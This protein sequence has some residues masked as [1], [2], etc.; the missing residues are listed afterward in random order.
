MKKKYCNHSLLWEKKTF[1]MSSSNLFKAKRPGLLSGFK[2][3]HQVDIAEFVQPEV[4]DGGCDGWEVV[5]LEAGITEANSSAQSR[6]NP[7]V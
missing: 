3:S 7:S 1:R 4:I 5:G 6:Q 2:V